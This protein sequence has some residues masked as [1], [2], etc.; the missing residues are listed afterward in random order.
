DSACDDGC[1]NSTPAVHGWAAAKSMQAAQ[2]WLNF[3]P[4][5][6]GFMTISPSCLGNSLCQIV[7]NKPLSDSWP[8]ALVGYHVYQSIAKTF[9]LCLMDYINEAT[10]GNCGHMFPNCNVK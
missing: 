9:E 5:T 7:R 1:Q 8:H 4:S 6:L 2:T 10:M 3:S